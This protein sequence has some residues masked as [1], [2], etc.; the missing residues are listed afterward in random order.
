VE[1]GAAFRRLVLDQVQQ[2]G[3]VAGPDLAQ[4]QR[5]ADFRRLDQF[6][7]DRALVR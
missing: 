2:H 1:A 5:I 3:L 6:C 4:K 7:E